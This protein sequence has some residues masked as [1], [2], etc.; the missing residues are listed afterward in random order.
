MGEMGEEAKGKFLK[1]KKISVF[2]ED[3]KSE[4][5]HLQNGSWGEYVPS[6]VYYNLYIRY[7]PTEGLT[8]S[9]IKTPFI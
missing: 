7:L 9:E 6:L 3:R 5:Q 2:R 4:K 1:K 8:I